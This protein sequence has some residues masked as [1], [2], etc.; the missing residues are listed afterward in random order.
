MSFSLVPFIVTSQWNLICL[1]TR[2][3]MTS[4]EFHVAWERHCIFSTVKMSDINQQNERFAQFYSVVGHLVRK[5]EG[6]GKRERER[7]KEHFTMPKRLI[8]GVKSIQFHL[9]VKLMKNK[10]V[11]LQ[12]RCHDCLV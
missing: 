9:Y 12:S 7:E 5:D 3:M 1:G 10:K 4:A 8:G 11:K 2:M 6:E